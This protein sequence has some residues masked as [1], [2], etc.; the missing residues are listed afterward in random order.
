[1][2]MLLCAT[3]IA[4]WASGS[5]LGP[6]TSNSLNPSIKSLI[7]DLV[8]SE[9]FTLSPPNSNYIQ[10]FRI[11]LPIQRKTRHLFLF[12]ILD[13]P[14]YLDIIFLPWTPTEHIRN[15]CI[16]AIQERIESL[17]NLANVSNVNMGYRLWQGRKSMLIYGITKSC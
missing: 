8:I 11:G 13:P 4:V 10:S 7:L 16:T 9:I 3:T 5:S 12:P 1:M 17:H 14:V 15:R 2:I 6:Q